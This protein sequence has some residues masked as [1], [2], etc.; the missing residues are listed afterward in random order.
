MN[1]GNWMSGLL[2]AGL[3]HGILGWSAV[4]SLAPTYDEPV[5]LAAGVSYWK[6]GRYAM[7]GL[8]HPPAAEM[9][10]AL[11]VY[12]SDAILPT[13]DPYWIA[14]N[15][16]PRAQYEFADRFLYRN[17][18]SA[19]DML[20]RGRTMQLV[21]SSF[22]V[23]G[24]GVAA[25]TVA[26]S[27]AGVIAAGMA[28]CSTTLLAHGTLISNDLLFSW[29]TFFFFAFLPI[30]R[31]LWGAVLLGIFLGLSLGS[32]YAAVGFFGALAALI[33][34]ALFKKRL[35]RPEVK[36]PLI[37]G[38]SA[39]V[40]LLALF[41]FTEA[42]IYWDGLRYFIERASA[43][44]SSFFFGRHGT[45]GFLAYFP[46][47]FL[48]KTELPLLASLAAAVVLFLKG[49]LKVPARI[50]LPP[51]VFFGVVLLSKVQIG[52]RYLLPVY[53]FLIVIAGTALAA[54]PRSW[55][56]GASLLAVGWMAWTATAIRPHFLAFF[57]EAAGGPSQGYRYF[58]DSNVDWGQGLS[59]L[60]AALDEQT[61]KSG[62]YLCYFGVAD[63]HAYGIRYL[64]VASDP[65]A[66][67]LDDS[68]DKTLSPTTFVIS[69]TKLQATY[70]ADKTLFQWLNQYQPAKLV[71]N[72]L[73]VYD[74]SNHPEALERLKSLHQLTHG[75]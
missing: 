35:L 56:W 58:T 49:T 31:K 11:P 25:W 10:A 44:R 36:P 68:S 9:A 62:I 74:F 8:H 39:C 50:L 75:I 19:H 32:K 45:T 71:A 42:G 59:F 6:S 60:P 69:A 16:N 51:L 21:L 13:L 23:M 72:S 54:L 65:L 22:L 52:H 43:G 28:A 7:N 61:K 47:A 1:R 33:G 55:R 40:F 41:R 27:A 67:H 14:Q 30:R 12:F 37:I 57:N 17:R 73:F 2:C 63:P 34:W 3:L 24:I 26:G 70:F 48:M 15:W 38:V 46:M 53:P 64:N 5:H 29:G 4:W 66:G 20:A 18:L